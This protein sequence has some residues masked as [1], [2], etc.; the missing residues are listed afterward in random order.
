MR[1][2]WQNLELRS[3]LISS[4]VK[5][6]GRGNSCGELECKPAG[7]G[8]TVR[9]QQRWHDDAIKDGVRERHGCERE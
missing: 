8:T 5:V 4:L 1:I 7:A 9:A 6:S 2:G 3:S